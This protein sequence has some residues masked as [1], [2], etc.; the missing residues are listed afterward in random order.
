MT[1]LG[2]VNATDVAE[3]IVEQLERRVAGGTAIKISD[4]TYRLLDQLEAEE[5]TDVRKR[6]AQADT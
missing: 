2:S 1:A 6:G 5:W 4:C 3:A